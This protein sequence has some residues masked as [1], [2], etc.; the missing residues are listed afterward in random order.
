MSP[1]DKKQALKEQFLKLRQSSKEPNEVHK[2]FGEVH[3]A[4]TL[5]IDFP[6]GELIFPMEGN[7]G[8]HDFCMVFGDE[9]TGYNVVEL[10][11]KAAGVSKGVGSSWKT[12][13]KS[14]TFVETK[15]W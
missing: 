8:F 10:P 11:V 4:A 12:I 1:D 15:K 3:A 7:A 13:Y 2:N 6:D 5:A 14:F 9:S